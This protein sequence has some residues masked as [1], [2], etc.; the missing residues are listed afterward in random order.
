[1]EQK[2]KPTILIVNDDLRLCET[3]KMLLENCGAEVYTACTHPS[4]LVEKLRLPLDLVLIDAT[5]VGFEQGEYICNAVK[6]LDSS[7]CVAMLAKPEM[8]V[9]ESTS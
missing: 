7:R 5:N 9:N 8:G 2:I 4:D 3:R 6:K 1:M